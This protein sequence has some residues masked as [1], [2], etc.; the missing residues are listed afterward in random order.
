[1]RKKNGFSLL[2]LMITISVFAILATIAIPNL[3]DFLIRTQRQQ[4][5]SDLS[6]AIAI[7]R[8]EAV[9]RALPVTLAGKTSGSQMLQEG[10]QIF[11]DPARTGTY[12]A[13]AGSVTTLIAE[14]SAYPANQLL[15]GRDASPQV[16]AGG[17]EYLQ[18]DSL[19][20]IST[21]TGSN[22]SYGVTV[23]VQR[24]GVD[25]VKSALCIGWAGRVRLVTD[26]ANSDSGACVG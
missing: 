23:V 4:V 20:R 24:N 15:V 8:S 3:Q 2:E 11:T 14:Q 26:K 9:K 7:A 10:W 18:F 12:S 16:T 25:K 1:M 6:T 5:I 17:A 19:G 22:G 13:S 21:L